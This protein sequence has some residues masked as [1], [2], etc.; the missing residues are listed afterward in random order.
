MKTRKLI[1]LFVV[2]ALLITAVATIAACK[3]YECQN[4]CE[5]CGKCL[6]TDC[7]HEACADKC[8]GHTVP[9]PPYE[10]NNKCATGGKCLTANCSH[11]ECA[12][13]CPGHQPAPYEC[14][15]KCEE[16]GKCLTEDC[17]HEA[18][19]DKCLGHDG[20][21]DYECQNKCEECGKCLT[22]GCEHEECEEKCPVGGD[23][24]GGDD[25]ECQN[26]CEECGKCLTEDCEHEECEEKCPVGGNHVVGDEP[27]VNEAFNA[28][29]IT[30]ADNT[31]TIVMINDDGSISVLVAQVGAQD[32]VEI[33]LTYEITEEGIITIKE[34]DEAIGEG[35]IV[36]RTISISISK[37]SY[38]IER[39]LYEMTITIDGDE[40]MMYCAEGSPLASLYL[41][42]AEDYDI[43]VDGEAL[44][45]EEMLSYVMPA[46]NIQVVLTEKTQP[47]EEYTITFVAGSHGTLQG[48]ATAQTVNGKLA[49]LPQVDTDSANCEL[50]GWFTAATG[51]EQVTTATV[52]EE[53]TT[54]YA[55][56]KHEY[57]I[58]LNVDGS[59]GTLAGDK[60]SFVTVDGKI[61]EALPLNVTVTRANFS[62]RGWF[63]ADGKT[64]VV[65]N[66]TVFTADT[67]I[68]AKITPKDGV[69][70]NFDK[71]N[72]KYIAL[73][74]NN[75]AS[76]ENLKAEYWMGDGQTVELEKDDE[77]R[78][79][80]GGVQCTGVYIMGQGVTNI[81]SN[82]AT[83]KVVTPGEYKF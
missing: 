30:V 55:Q 3:Q 1:A 26:K 66:V 49:A 52:F 80:I 50:I 75:G 64:E 23:H 83:V 24:S 53:D 4:K 54:I 18:C 67:E 2:V 59:L 47:A 15:N 17:E 10:C 14:Q 51:G 11:A 60:L 39:D 65:E 46:K 71:S 35:S 34:N 61:T 63:K 82:V 42:Y 40:E 41:E 28:I 22:I 70:V 32:G 62:F 77:L 7:E 48:E 69:W 16:C 73:V 38:E 56:Y 57:L 27:I 58:T 43:T 13:K 29:I 76:G 37:Y 9:N 8:Q 5:E 78:W 45:E 25:Y 74:R 12:Q 21:N 81:G 33:K 68:Y 20:G 44:S 72:E 6:T 79:Y 19:A 36:G 31:M